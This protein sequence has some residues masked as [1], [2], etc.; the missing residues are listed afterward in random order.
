MKMTN[1]PSVLKRFWYGRFFSFENNKIIEYEMTRKRE[2]VSFGATSDDECCQ[3]VFHSRAACCRLVPFPVI[4]VLM[5]MNILWW[6]INLRFR[7][8][9]NGYQLLLATE[10]QSDIWI[11][12]SFFFSSTSWKNCVYIFEYTVVF[13]FHYDL[14]S[15]DPQV[16]T[17][18]SV[19]IMTIRLNRETETWIY[20]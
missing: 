13:A 4:V 6:L 3:L 11:F 18:C 2:D 1:Y 19:A 17:N 20:W 7:Q 12:F 15:L 16:L 14:R 9:N 8:R 5:K 10:C